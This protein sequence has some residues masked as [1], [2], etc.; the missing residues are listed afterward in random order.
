MSSVVVV[1]SL[2][3][4]PSIVLLSSY[5]HIKKTAVCK[6]AAVDE[7]FSVL[8]P[9]LEFS[10]YRYLFLKMA[11]LYWWGGG[12]SMGELCLVAQSCYGDDFRY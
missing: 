3:I 9:F 11:P 4:A 5:N 7:R 8:F 6:T 10:N 12:F 2:T 1:S